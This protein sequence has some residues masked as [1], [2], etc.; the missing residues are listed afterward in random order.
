MSSRA[1]NRL[2]TL[3][4]GEKESFSTFLPHFEKELANSRL[5]DASD[6][7]AISYLKGALNSQMSMALITMPVEE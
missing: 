2:R 1:I 3:R 5:R 4:Q 6:A 7:V